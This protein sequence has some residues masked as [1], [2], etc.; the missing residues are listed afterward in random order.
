MQSCKTAQAALFQGVCNVQSVQ[1]IFTIRNIFIKYPW[2]KYST[3]S[4]IVPIQKVTANLVVLNLVVK[5]HNFCQRN[6]YKVGFNFS[7]EMILLKLAKF[8]LN[9]QIMRIIVIPPALIG[10]LLDQI[11]STANMNHVC[12][13]SI[14]RCHE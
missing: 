7:L 14:H 5:M 10:L 8:R 6:S 2:T 4:K 9:T 3:I 11:V 12:W 13:V 1:G